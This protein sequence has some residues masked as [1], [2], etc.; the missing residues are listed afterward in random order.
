MEIVNVNTNVLKENGNQIC[1]M[2]LGIMI[3]GR[4]DFDR[5][6]NNLKSIKDVID[7]IK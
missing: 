3:R 7:I 5:L 4:E 2:H 6:A 1:L